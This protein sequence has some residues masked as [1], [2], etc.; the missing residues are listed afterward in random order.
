M[1]EGMQPSLPA[2]IPSHLQ[3][4]TVLLLNKHWVAISAATPADA[5]GH[6]VTGNARALRVVDGETRAYTWPEWRDLPVNQGAVSIGTPRGRVL[7][8]TVLVLSRYAWVPLLSVAAMNSEDWHENRVKTEETAFDTRSEGTSRERAEKRFF[9]GTSRQP[10]AARTAKRQ[11]PT[12][13]VPATVLIRNHWD[14]KD[15]NHF[16]S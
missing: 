9:P 11:R 2:M 8:P 10:Q 16:I 12:R 1:A 13:L 5:F 7:I 4:S 15:W 3:R 6:L 14:I